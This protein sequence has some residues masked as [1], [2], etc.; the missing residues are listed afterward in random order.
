M[1][2]AICQSVYREINSD[3]QLTMFFNNV[4]RALRVKLLFEHSLCH[5]IKSFKSLL[6][7]LFFVISGNESYFYLSGNNVKEVNILELMYEISSY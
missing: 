5:S 4:L 1:D 7:L 6:L 2:E 3:C